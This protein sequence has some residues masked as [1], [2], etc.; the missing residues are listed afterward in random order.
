[1]LS[2]EDMSQELWPTTSFETQ[3]SIPAYM[4]PLG[5]WTAVLP[6]CILITEVLQEVKLS[7]GCFLFGRESQIDHY[8]LLLCQ[9]CCAIL[10]QI[11]APSIATDHKSFK[12]LSH[13]LTSMLLNTSHCVRV[14]GPHRLH[15]A[16]GGSEPVT[17]EDTLA[18]WPSKWLEVLSMQIE[19]QRKERWRVPGHTPAITC[20]DSLMIYHPLP[21]G[22]FYLSSTKWCSLY[23]SSAWSS[24]TSL[25]HHA[26]LLQ[27]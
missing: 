23:M 13:T 16:A 20:S 15:A 5:S 17:S 26:N 6:F 14:P 2:K 4:H 25:Q 3:K 11:H 12:R 24:D 21:Q 8:A 7:L 22:S 10:Q 18:T 9:G 1:M 27:L 19:T